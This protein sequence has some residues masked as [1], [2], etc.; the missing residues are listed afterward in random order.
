[1]FWQRAKVAL[2]ASQHNVAIV[3]GLGN[4]GELF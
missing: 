1:M 4:A 2:A 3:G